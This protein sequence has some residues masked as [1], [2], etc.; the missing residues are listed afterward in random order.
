MICLKYVN[1]RQGKKNIPRYSNGSALIENGTP[2]VKGGY[3]ATGVSLGAAGGYV[4]YDMNVANS[5]TTPYGVDFIVYGNAFVGNPEAAS[6][7][8]IPSMV[9]PVGT[10]WPA[11]STTP[12]RPCATWT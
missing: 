4:E 8:G 11:P 5:N 2:K 1:I 9:R 7:S 10:S 12:T 6:V 3:S